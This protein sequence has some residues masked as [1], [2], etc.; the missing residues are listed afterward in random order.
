MGMSRGEMYSE[1][2]LIRI[3]EPLIE[4]VYKDYADRQYKGQMAH[5]D[6]PHGDPWHTGFHA[7]S[8]P[9]GDEMAC[10]RESLYSMMGISQDKPFSPK[11]LKMMQMGKDVE[12]DLV[13][14]LYE[15]GIL[16]SPTP[17]NP[18][19]MGF[20]DGDYWLSGNLDAL[21]AH[22]GLGRPH[23]IE[24]KMKYAEVVQE[25]LDRVQGPDPKHVKQLKTYICF[26]RAKI[27]EQF[28]NMEPLRD[29]TIVYIS[30][31]NP[32]VTAEFLVEYDESFM[33]EGLKQLAEWKEFYRQGILPSTTPDKRNPMGFRWTYP[34]CNWCDFGQT[35][36]K[37]HKAGVTKLADSHGIEFS[38]N[39]IRV[40]RVDEEGE[41][42]INPDIDRQYMDTYDYAEKRAQVF[43]RWGEDDPL[44]EKHIEENS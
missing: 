25:M 6:S 41:P 18:I 2:G 20:K 35:C 30:R 24:C 13:W 29:G 10:P 5:L 16:L 34:P 7:S 42:V 22:P 43:A 8:F 27:A 33:E 26:M 39:V 21:I 31:D 14:K 40:P 28:P 1:L 37:D 15:F 9:G 23:V 19:Q 36:R 17:D 3:M 11:S 32:D 44:I 38:Q 12:N 4:K